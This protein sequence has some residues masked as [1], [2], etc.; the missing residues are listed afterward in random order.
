MITPQSNSFVDISIY[1]DY[2]YD[3]GKIEES[4]EIQFQLAES[5][6]NQWSREGV[7]GVGGVGGGVGVVG[8]VGVVGG[9]V[10]GGGGG[11]GGGVVGR[12]VGRVVGVGGGGGG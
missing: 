7:G 5:T 6:T 12:G 1:S 11:V 4:L 9:G 8:V 10:G 3:Q 2:L